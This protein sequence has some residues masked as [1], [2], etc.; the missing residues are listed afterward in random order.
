[1]P[2]MA[3]AANTNDVKAG[4][5]YYEYGATKHYTI[6]DGKVK[7]NNTNN[8]KAIEKCV[9]VVVAP[10]CTT[11][12]KVELTC[13]APLPDGVACDQ[14]KTDEIEKLGHSN[15]RVNMSLEAYA[16]Q[17]VAQ[18]ENTGDF[19]NEGKAKAWVKTQKNNNVCYVLAMRCK[20]CG[21]VVGYD[22]TIT[23]AQAAD[24]TGT[25]SK[26]VL[27]GYDKNTTKTSCAE[28]VQCSNVGCN[29]MV[30]VADEDRITTHDLDTSKA[31]KTKT[32]CGGIEV[33]KTPCKN[34]E[35]VDVSK[36]GTANCV[37]FKGE[38]PFSS[39]R[40]S[41]SKYLYNGKVIANYDSGIKAVKGYYYDGTNNVFVKADT[42]VKIG[43]TEYF[44]YTCKHCGYVRTLN[45]VKV[46]SAVCNHAW[47]KVTE[48]ATCEAAAQEYM[49]CT[50]CGKY[51]TVKDDDDVPGSTDKVTTAV[52]GSKALGHNYVAT[53]V[54]GDCH[55]TDKYT[56]ECTRENCP[57]KKLADVNRTKYTTLDKGASLY[58]DPADGS[59]GQK[60]VV[61]SQEL[62]YIADNTANNHKFTKKVTLKAATCTNNELV[63]YVCD[64]CGKINIH[65]ATV[66]PSTKLAHTFVKDEVPATCGKAGY[67]TEK[68]SVCG[69]YQKEDGT[70]SNDEVRVN[71]KPV[72]KEGVACAD[73]EWVVTKPATVFAEGVKSLVCSKCGNV[74]AKTV[75]AKK[76]VAKASN[77]VKAGKKSFNVKSSAANATGYR[78]Y[79]KKA[80]AKSWKSYTKKTTSLSKTFS[81]LS[82][83]KYYVKVR[84]YAKNYDGDGQVVWGATSSTKSVKVK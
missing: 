78:V 42:T 17:R 12:G 15:E 2:S 35:H 30:A 36:T 1:M 43:T 24:E 39:V 64:T 31:T 58:L 26:L 11:K 74:D 80:G 5:S 23:P 51:K 63:G 33:T 3:F 69:V 72:V 49:V 59:V 82:K 61:G 73:L 48:D 6:V 27:H 34:C 55:D 77:T 28:K 66:V 45:D 53:K 62:P 29:E 47:K 16:A 76:T 40:K 56:I 71:I 79:Y 81:G 13:K 20:S 60:N 8:Q 67:Y 57:H 4:H 84:A 54:E 10:T 38:I 7:A 14:V 70:L 83:G 65:S 44:G 32:G 21:T 52:E 22:A 46:E 37:E 19:I 18:K 25:N 9:K 75:I 50:E 41:G 68:C